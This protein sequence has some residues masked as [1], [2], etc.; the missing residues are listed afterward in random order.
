MTYSDTRTATSTWHM[1]VS[2]VARDTG[3]SGANG[4]F[5]LAASTYDSVDFDDEAEGGQGRDEG[6]EEEA[7]RDTGAGAVGLGSGAEA[8]ANSNVARGAGARGDAAVAGYAVRSEARGGW[9]AGADDG[10]VP[11]Q[12]GV[13]GEVRG[14]RRSQLEELD[15]QELVWGEGEGP[16]GDEAEDGAGKRTGPPAR[17]GF[18][19]RQQ[20]NNLR[21]N[22]ATKRIDWRADLR[23]I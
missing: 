3:L 8:I 1:H 7:A 13:S 19:A 10:R 18:K 20:L 6:D 12:L 14:G 16:S 23:R 11:V 17:A 22:L 5:E 9:R 2:Q 15:W 4:L 21:A